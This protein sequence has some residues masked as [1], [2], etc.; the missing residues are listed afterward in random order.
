ML[1]PASAQ[2]Q[3]CVRYARQLTSF[4]IQGDAWTWWQHAEGRYQR[5]VRPAEGSV[6]VF[7]RTGHLHYGHVSVVSRV[8]DRRT[9][10]VDHSW[11]EGTVLHRGMKVIDTSPNNT[12]SSVKVWYDPADRLGIRTYPTFGFIYPR[13]HRGFEQPLTV[14][15]NER[16]G[17]HDNER[18]GPAAVRPAART[19]VA[20]A[21]RAA[22]ASVFV[23]HRKPASA[24]PA[25]TVVAAAAPADPAPATGLYG[26]PRH[27]PGPAVA[28][29]AA[30]ATAGTQLAE[31]PQ[32]VVPRRKPIG[33]GGSQQVAEARGRD[34]SGLND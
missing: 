14:A 5:G 21:V 4:T 27:K 8:I 10:L 32:V 13:G 30:G 9:I 28:T 31:V 25:P 16:D 20:P 6:L 26:A 18:D 22:V 24:G 33:H 7:R 19:P 11:L 17:D 29:A 15:A 1:V 2:A 12:W 34:G 23:P 3:M